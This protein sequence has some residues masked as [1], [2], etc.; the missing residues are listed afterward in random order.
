MLLRQPHSAQRDLTHYRMPVFNSDRL[1]VDLGYQIAFKKRFG[2]MVYGSAAFW[3]ATILQNKP[4][5][6]YSQLSAGLALYGSFQLLPN[7]FVKPIGGIYYRTTTRSDNTNYSQKE[8][9][10]YLACGFQIPIDKRAWIQATPAYYKV[11]E[12]YNGYLFTGTLG[13]G[14]QF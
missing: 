13:F 6:N 10:L 12:S 2:M 1:T 11:S 5:F 9:P 8:L 4:A 14:Y 3:S 7:F